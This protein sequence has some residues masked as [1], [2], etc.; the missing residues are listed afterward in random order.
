[1]VYYVVLKENNRISEEMRKII[2][3]LELKTYEEKYP[4][5]EAIEVYKKGTLLECQEFINSIRNLKL[6]KEFEIIQNKD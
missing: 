4:I 1:M 3:D 2:E 6:Q 5:E